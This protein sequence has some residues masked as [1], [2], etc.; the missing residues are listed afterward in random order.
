VKSFNLL[1]YSDGTTNYVLKSAITFI[2]LDHT[3]RSIDSYIVDGVEYFNLWS[4]VSETVY[5]YDPDG[6]SSS[7]REKWYRQYSGDSSPTLIQQIL[8]SN[9]N[10]RYESKD[11]VIV[12]R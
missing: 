8:Q 11:F 3:S 5:Y 10:P 6:G 2:Q 9:G 7:Y 1:T 4:E 12:F